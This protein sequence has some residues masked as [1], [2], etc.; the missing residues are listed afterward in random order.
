M[1]AINEME[2]ELRRVVRHNHDIYGMPDGG[3]MGPPMMKINYP[4]LRQ[5]GELAA[6]KIGDKWFIPA[7]KI[8]ASHCEHQWKE[9]QNASS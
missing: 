8:Q 7:N 5:V 2:I 1:S 9:S 6:I 4:V 3:W